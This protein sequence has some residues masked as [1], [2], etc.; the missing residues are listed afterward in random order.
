M[1]SDT[2]SV[3]YYN[4]PAPPALPEGRISWF[5]LG[6][7]TNNTSADGPDMGDDPNLVY[8]FG[9]TGTLIR[10]QFQLQRSPSLS[11]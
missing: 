8:P 10:S 1:L 9:V 3:Q 2:L 5:T 6:S 11:L 7:L 4:P